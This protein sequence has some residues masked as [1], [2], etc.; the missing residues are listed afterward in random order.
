M[1]SWRIVL[2]G[3]TA[4]VA[5]LG[6]P[7]AAQETGVATAE[8][9]Q[10][11]PESAA[12]E[13]AAPAGEIVVTAQR[14]TE[15]LSRVPVAVSAFNAEILQQR[16]V[17]REQDLAS[18]VPGLIVKS[19]QNTN[20]ISF[21]MRG[22][23][24]DP[25]SGTSPAVLTYVN[26]APFTGGNSA[27]AFFDFSSLQV[28]KG[29][30]GTLFGRNATGGAVLYE[31]TKPGD[32]F[33]G[34]V[35][36]RAGERQLIQ[37]QGAV[38]L[39]LIPDRLLIRV[40]GDFVKSDGYIKNI[41]TGNTLGDTNSKSGRITVV[42]KPTDTFVN[43]FVGQ[44][45]KLG[46][47][48]GVG[49]LSSYYPCGST[50]NGFILVT[51]LDCVY[52]PNS[53]FAPTLGD[54]PRGPGTWPG[55]TAG[56]LAFQKKNPYKIWL[57]FDLPHK[58]HIAYI[59]NS[60]R[61]ELNDQ[62]AIKNT[63]SW[64]DTFAR[65]PG[66]LSGSPFGAIDLY[67]FSG[68]GNGPPGGETFDVRRWSNELQLQGKAFDGRFDFIAGLFYERKRQTDYIPVVVGPELLGSSFNGG[69]PLADIAYFYST[70]NASK[71][72]FGQG[73]YKL[74]DALSVTLGGR[75]TWETLKIN[76]EEGA[77]FTLPF[78]PTPP[79]Q[80]K[81][82]SAPSWTF[83]LQYQA[84]SE[85][86]IYFAQRGS[87]RS[88]NYNGTVAPF[89]D[90]NAFKNEY[91]HD[92]ELGYKFSGRLGSVPANFN[93]AIYQQ[94]VKDAQRFVAVLVAGNP[95]GFTVNVPKARARGV[96]V[97]GNIRPA[98]WLN[99]GFSGAYTKAEYTDNLVDL[100]LQVGIPGFVVPFDSY[101]DS[102]KWAGS[103]YA[104]I[105]LPVP[106]SLGEVVLH[107]DTF[108]QTSS[109]FSS[110]ANSITPETKLPGYTVTNVRLSWNE[111]MGS[112]FSA[113]VYVKN[114]FDKLYYSSGYQEG[115]S[116]GFNTALWGEPRT[117]AGELTFKF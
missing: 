79:R 2:L 32:D 30:Q 40:A 26:E 58:A 77:L 65:T 9:A 67:N 4:V 68:L 13:G 101:P 8:G 75:Y 73:T 97:D 63:F 37:A 64:G 71:A 51:T 110:N 33:G 62:L 3:G 109:Y 29:P 115:A 72:V 100:S 99:L 20:Q 84:D 87:F 31:T 7:V 80:S 90:L 47:T 23:T 28:L 48:E 61:L 56:Y 41:N 12:T 34:Y 5:A 70:Q 45:S 55:A 52:G 17:N 95:A 105:T 6:S 117:V 10:T 91:T 14:R 19:G 38:D 89:G 88:G 24:L 92:F 113:A 60:T 111:I 36:L 82:I 18:L 42:A 43:T 1:N 108:G 53:P 49:G 57:S 103:V 74:T 114:V 21:T 35:T 27:S 86:M 16:V 116:G 104:D 44:Y 85:N 59:T 112:K 54:G 83:N 15:R 66:I 81:S 25:F 69:L 11:A 39:P 22:Q 106:E 107:G 93:L 76:Q 50:N 46:G 98:D 102:P 94:N 78:F 96:E